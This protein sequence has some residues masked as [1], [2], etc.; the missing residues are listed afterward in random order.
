MTAMTD[1]TGRRWADVLIGLLMTISL[2]LSSWSLSKV[3]EH[4]KAIAIIVTTLNRM[5]VTYPPQD[6]RDMINERFSQLTKRL[7]ENRLILRDIQKNVK[8]P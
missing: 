1:A 6:Y 4:E 5:P 3:V 2:A 7:E 8:V